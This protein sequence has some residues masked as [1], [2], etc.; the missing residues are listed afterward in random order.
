MLELLIGMAA[1]T[2]LLSFPVGRYLLAAVASLCV[3]LFIAFVFVMVLA[4]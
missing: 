3:L 4:P 1:L 2:I